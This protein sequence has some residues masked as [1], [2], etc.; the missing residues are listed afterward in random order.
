MGFVFV[1]PVLQAAYF[2]WVVLVE[3]ESSTDIRIARNVYLLD[4]HDQL[5][6][7]RCRSI[8]SLLGHKCGH[9]EYLKDLPT[10]KVFQ[11]SATQ[12][13]LECTTL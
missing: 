7:S 8:L 11:R 4:W 9:I 10:A 6:D 2:G 1:H 3:S 12:A 5:S 13:K